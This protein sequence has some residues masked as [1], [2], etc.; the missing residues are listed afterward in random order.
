LVIRGP[1]N[2]PLVAQVRNNSADDSFAQDLLVGGLSALG[3]IGAVINAPEAVTTATSG[4]TGGRTQTQTTTTV[5]SGRDN[6]LWGAALEGFFAP[7]SE[8]VSERFDP[9]NQDPTQPYLYVPQ[10]QTVSVFVNGVLEV[11]R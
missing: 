4:A 9:R 3:N 1:N 5:T 2:Q 11:A 6:N 10:G 7:I 8:R